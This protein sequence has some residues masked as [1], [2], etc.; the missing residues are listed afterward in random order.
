MPINL[1]GSLELTGSLVISGSITTTG[2]ITI[3]GS[4]ASSSFAATASSADNFLTRGTL[5]AQT[6]VVQ[7][8]TSSVMYSSGS[9]IFGNN[10]ANTQVLTG[11]VTVTGSLAV[12]TTGTEFQV[13]STGVNL[14]NALTD[15]H[16]ISGSLRVNPNG[17]FVSSSGIVGIG[18][19]TPS[20]VL[21]ISGSVKIGNLKIE[22]SDGGKI[23]FN[24]NTANGAIYNSGYSAFQI[25]GAYSGA[26][27]LD[28]QNYNSSGSYLGSFVFKDGN[29]GI[30]TTSPLAKL[31]VGNGTQSGINGA[32][33]KIHIASNTS[34]GRSA[35]LT[36]ANSSGAV[37]V[38]GQ[39]ESS[40]ESADLRVII[41]STSNHDVVLRSNN[42]E[43][44]RITSG[45]NIGIGTTTPTEIFN[46]NVGVG[47]RAGMALTGEYPYLRFNVT[48]SS[49]NARNWAF[50][51]TNTEAGDFALLQST[52]KDG[53]PVTA[54]TSLM[55]FSRG[56]D[57]QFLNAVQQ[58]GVWTVFS[59]GYT[60]GDSSFNF[61]VGVG[62]EGGGGNIFKVEAGFAHYFAMSYNCLAEFYISTR[63]TGTEITDVI[64]R[65]TA[66]AGSFTASKPDSS[67]LRVTKTAGSYGGSG[68]YWIKVTKVNY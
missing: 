4:I 35:L 61:D 49:A 20:E 19:T 16:V 13:T 47:A 11:S 29:I 2:P 59:T 32:G 30:G 40:A 8:I 45:G 60:S 58:Q 10:I 17:L 14:G 34:G 39:F 28:F 6:L 37:T 53:N 52:A 65:D 46:V 31:Q 26:N 64:R 1:S 54:G 27:Y 23:G 15:S 5:T 48:S 7:T 50:N 3:S 55:Y 43:R 9:N 68:R 57:V 12:V 42:I 56:G 25:N 36:L 18:T 66:L 67:T 21:D 41:G 63:A 33:N 44:M 24:R 38:E 62:D 22:N 51:T